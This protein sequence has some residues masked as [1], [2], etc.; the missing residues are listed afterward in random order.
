MME[1]VFDWM[2]GWIVAFCPYELESCQAS[3]TCRATLQAALADGGLG[4][5]EFVAVSW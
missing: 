1:C 3:Q 4:G 5:D 2:A